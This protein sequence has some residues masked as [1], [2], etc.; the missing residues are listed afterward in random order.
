MAGALLHDIGKIES[1]LG[2]PGRVLATIV[3]PRTTR[4]RTYLEHESRG[5][6]LLEQVGSD[7]VTID[8]V[9]R[10]GASSEALRAVDDAVVAQRPS[11]PMAE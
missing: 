8:L 10:R 1:D 3:G 6:E 4:L 2:V 9:A 5:V 7:P 11:R